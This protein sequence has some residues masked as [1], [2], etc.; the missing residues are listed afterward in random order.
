MSALAMEVPRIELLH[1][2][3]LFDRKCLENTATGSKHFERL[4]QWRLVCP[5]EVFVG[6]VRETLRDTPD[7]EP[8]L[9]LLAARLAREEVRLIREQ[10]EKDVAAQK[11]GAFEFDELL[12]LDGWENFF[13]PK[14]EMTGGRSERPSRSQSPHPAAA[15]REGRVL[16]ETG[17][18]VTEISGWLA[19][20]RSA[21]D[22]SPLVALKEEAALEA[23]LVYGQS[24]RFQAAFEILDRGELN[25]RR[26]WIA[27][28]VLSE[29][30]AWTDKDGGGPLREWLRGALAKERPEEITGAKPRH[31][32][33]WLQSLLLEDG[34]GDTPEARQAWKLAR[35]RELW[36]AYPATGD[37]AKIR[38][39]VEKLKLANDFHAPSDSQMTLRELLTRAQSQVRLIDGNGGLRT[40]KRVLALPPAGITK[41]D[42]WTALQLHSRILRILDL[43]HQIPS[44]I[45]SYEERAHF[46]HVGSDEDFPRAFNRLIEISKQLWTYENGDAAQPLLDTILAHPRATEGARAQALYVKAR[47]LEQSHRPSEAIAA[48][49]RAL[50][51]RGLAGDLVTDLIWRKL[52]LLFDRVERFGGVSPPLQISASAREIFDALA[53]ARKVTSDSF[54]RARIVYWT[55]RAYEIE[56]RLEEAKKSYREGFRMEA[57]SYYSNLSGLALTRL[58][59]KLKDWHVGV[60]DAHDE[61]DVESFIRNPRKDTNRQ[62][63]RIYGLARLGDATGIDRAM[64]EFGKDVADDLLGKSL[65]TSEKRRIGRAAAWLRRAVGDAFGS[66]KT[67]E[68][69]RTAFVDEFEGEDYAYL[70]PLPYWDLIK[71]A[72]EKNDL[73]PW[74]VASLI[75]QESAFDSNAR[76]PA[77]ALGL[78]QMIPP[79]AKAEA[80]KV[81][82]SDFENEDLY[83]P[84]VAIR[85]GTSHLGG[86]VKG[87]Q[88]SFICSFA[89]YNAGRPPVDKWLGYYPAGDPLSFVERIPYQETRNYVRSILRNFINY[90]RIYGDGQVDFAQLTRM[91]PTP[92]EMP[93]EVSPAS[94]EKSGVS[95]PEVR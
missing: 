47:I 58:G 26:G 62:F 21:A 79:V 60:T 63:A 4:V 34:Q 61:P 20:V 55:A 84:E 25:M 5:R 91:P 75:R 48:M 14:T 15:S 16:A 28:K 59:E 93:S 68:V 3:P 19:P 23:F 51:R 50:E 94:P 95:A 87:L 22:S 69:A 72:A 82:M 36:V 77:N 2:G 13:F 65:K 71:A 92:F 40:M 11:A 64:P 49:N 12:S 44:L 31:L 90:R 74:V 54:D 41:D 8:E 76:S 80:K 83:A 38:A 1:K 17:S 37:A 6:A 24:L 45:R 7:R 66:L 39:A 46:R 30:M 52:F 78:M 53:A 73:D 32:D 43:R 89:S 81:G 67:A 88:G 33:M 70:Y 57:L 85:L 29:V 10:V 27:D 35:L 56:G 18:L 86:L 9:R 42:Y